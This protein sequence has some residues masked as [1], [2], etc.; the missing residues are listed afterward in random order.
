MEIF[1]LLKANI[2]KK[3]STFISIMLL[4]AIIAAAMTAIFS[5]RDNCNA[6]MK[7][8]LEYADSGDIA[9]YVEEERLTEDIRS[10]IE[11]SPLT[12]RV[13]YYD[14]IVSGGIHNG[15]ESDSNTQFLMEMRKGIRLFNED[16]DGFESGIPELSRGEIYLP[17]GLKSKISCRIGDTVTLDLV[18]GSH[19]FTIKG[20]VQEPSFGSLSIG[21]KQVFISHEDFVSLYENCKPPETENTISKATMLM[22]YQAD[23][24]KLSV[25]KFQR[26][27]N[28]QTR[29]TDISLGALTREQTLQYSTLMPEMI[30]EIVLVF[31]V[32]LFIIV[33]IVMC[34]S[35]STEI[36]T[37]FKNLGILKSQGF[38]KGKIRA[39]LT[40]QYL[41]AQLIGIIVGSFAAIP[42]ENRISSFFRLV[43]GCLSGKGLSVGKSLLCM[44]AMMIISA[45]LIFVKTG[46]I[47]R[48][49]PVRAISGGR[50]E[51]WFDTPLNAPIMKKAL[52]ASLALRQFTSAWKRYIGT[53][54]IAAILTFFMITVN[55]IGTL[56]S[57]RNALSAMGMLLP[58]IEI[59]YT[60]DSEEINLN[61]MEDIVSSYSAIKEK[62]RRFTCYCSLNGENLYCEI[63]EKPESIGGIL[64]G[65]APL[66]ENEI[67]I[68][69]IVAD[70]LETGPG[71]ELTVSCSDGE[72]CFM[73][74]GIFQSNSDIGMT[75]AMNFRGAERLG[76]DTGRAYVY[77]SLEDKSKLKDIAD[78]INA[79]YGEF[80]GVN[81]YEDKNPV[82]KEYDTIVSALKIIIY[83]FS[84][85]FAFVVIRMVCTKTFVQ[86]RTDIGIYKAMGFGSDK[87]RLQFVI[88]FL[89][90]ALLGS[91][92]GTILSILFSE[93]MLSL[94]LSR[95]GLT[96]VVTEYT[97]VSVLLP[98]TAVSL[99]FGI[100]A[101]LVFR[102]IRKTAVR[103]LAV[104]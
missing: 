36:Q 75:F 2:R 74:S 62:N 35:I 58:D 51:I 20:F 24:N 98:M 67:L 12:G 54:F 39:V 103:E 71:E 70:I 6:A 7:D 80:L 96:K 23:A 49:S 16:I 73:V 30:T 26:E 25:M 38:S 78:E 52:S 93:K 44:L 82:E 40:L 33:L 90:I 87:L 8:A 102:N 29:I 9:V 3:K 43:T 31:A 22:I 81:I 92:I 11:N 55:L 99:S 104:E 77:F 32:F 91:F 21:W 37:D 34:H 69:R 95:I 59:F 18:S 10:G 45:V 1:I 53:M 15:G 61:Q 64:E 84:V 4:T 86:E 88:R 42:L 85:L 56:L 79:T 5:V 47:T 13:L 28:L 57:S 100:F 19:E 63:Y 89:I 14:S 50:E 27:L 97:A 46:K 48:I 60:G 68:T 41:L 94:F 17:L 65:R 66:Y 76:I 101:F 72:K 83:I